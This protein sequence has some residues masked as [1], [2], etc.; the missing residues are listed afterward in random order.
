[1]CALI[2][3]KETQLKAVYSQIKWQRINVNWQKH[4]S[5]LG[6][7]M[8]Y[9]FTKHFFHL[10]AKLLFCCLWIYSIQKTYEWRC[11]KTLECSKKR[12]A[13]AHILY[14]C[15][16]SRTVFTEVFIIPPSPIWK[17][18]QQTKRILELKETYIIESCIIEYN[19]LLSGTVHKYKI[20]DRWL[21]SAFFFWHSELMS[22]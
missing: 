7:S 22:S 11:W 3:C 20:I 4:S 19:S 13:C 10:I 8:L 17:P 12:S 14:P 15:S 18:K 2:F 6:C 9:L 5:P 21:S 16:C 1:M